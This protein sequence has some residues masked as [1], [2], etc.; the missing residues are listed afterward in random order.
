MNINI[1]DGTSPVVKHVDRLAEWKSR[2][3]AWSLGALVFLSL[4]GLMIWLLP[5]SRFNQL[6]VLI[7]TV[8][9]LI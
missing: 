6:N 8:L 2:L 4:S 9:G 5:F 1:N 7:H 3:T